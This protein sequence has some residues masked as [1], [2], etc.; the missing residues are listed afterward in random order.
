M[1]SDGLRKRAFSNFFMAHGRITKELERRMSADGVVSLEV[2]DVLLALEDAPDQRFRMSELADRIIYSRSGLTRLADRLEQ[3]GL[4]RRVACPNDRRAMHVEITELGLS[5]RLRAWPTLERG[6]QE[7]FG[8]RISDDEASSIE[9]AFA[10]IL[11]PAD[12]APTV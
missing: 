9:L 10:K 7:L 5:E 11:D 8:E 1:N 4:I 2:Y 6:I 3:K 12:T